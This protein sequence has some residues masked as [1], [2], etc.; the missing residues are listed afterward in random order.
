M[1]IKKDNTRRF[2]VKDSRSLFLDK[3]V[4]QHD[5]DAIIREVRGEEEKK[6]GHPAEVIPFEP[7]K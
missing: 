3:H 1:K 5:L 7:K 4:I 2:I 6:H